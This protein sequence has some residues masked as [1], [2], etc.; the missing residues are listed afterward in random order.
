MELIAAGTRPYVAICNAEDKFVLVSPCGP[1]L[2]EVYC[3]PEAL[4][5]TITK[6]LK[7]YELHPNSKP[8]DP[9]TR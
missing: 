1:H 8:R 6:F 9:S 4:I 2:M 3:T 5:M 7:V